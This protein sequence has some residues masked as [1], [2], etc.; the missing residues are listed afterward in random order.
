[1]SQFFKK[2]NILIYFLLFP[3]R[4]LKMFLCIV[5]GAVKCFPNILN[6]FLYL[7]LV[8]SFFPKFIIMCIQQ[9]MNMARKP[10]K[11]TFYQNDS[12]LNHSFEEK[13]GDISL[14]VYCKMCSYIYM[15]VWKFYQKN[16]T[17]VLC[18]VIN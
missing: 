5:L 1:M 14:F 2:I 16:E 7:V 12:V 8:C 13:K 15:S 18:M 10:N 6:T 11:F 4:I 17:E 9:I 3:P